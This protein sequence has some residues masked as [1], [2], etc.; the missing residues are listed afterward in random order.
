MH[1]WELGG[2]NVPRAEA[3]C[4][5]HIGPVAVCLPEGDYS[6]W[7][8]NWMGKRRVA[9]RYRTAIRAAREVV[10][11]QPFARMPGNVASTC[12]TTHVSEGETRSGTTSGQA[13][14]DA[15]QLSLFFAPA[16]C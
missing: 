14:G 11:T 15:C 5:T 8:G 16:T 13:K 9:A 10:M 2:N 1:R 7:A 3:R 6:G 12:A 4:S